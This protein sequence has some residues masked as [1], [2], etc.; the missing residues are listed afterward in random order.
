VSDHGLDYLI[1]GRKRLHRL[2][3]LV[4]D[5]PAAAPEALWPGGA[6]A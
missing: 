4:G 6:T 1:S 3:E 5:R 2:A